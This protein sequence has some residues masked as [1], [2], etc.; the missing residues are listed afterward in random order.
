MRSAQRTATATRKQVDKN[1]ERVRNKKLEVIEE[2]F[3]RG[4]RHGRKLEPINIE[5]EFNTDRPEFMLP[6]TS[7]SQSFAK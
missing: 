1:I 6:W 3:K 7:S 2:N 4:I 5:E